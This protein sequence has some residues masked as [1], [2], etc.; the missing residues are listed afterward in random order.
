MSFVSLGLRADILHAWLQWN[1]QYVDSAM[2]YYETGSSMFDRLRPLIQK[3]SL[4]LSVS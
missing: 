2:K 3:H 1:V 4:L